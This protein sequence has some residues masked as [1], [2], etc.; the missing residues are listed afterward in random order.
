MTD[1]REIAIT[2]RYSHSS[3]V[4]LWISRL[5]ERKKEKE[6]KK[7]W[8]F[9]D[10]LF[11]KQKK[12]YVFYRD[13]AAYDSR[14]QRRQRRVFLPP[15]S[16]KVPTMNS[17]SKHRLSSFVFGRSRFEHIRTRSVAAAL[18]AAVVAA[19]VAS[20]ITGT[21]SPLPPLPA[22]LPCP[23]VQYQFVRARRLPYVRLLFL[24]ERHVAMANNNQQR[25]DGQFLMRCARQQRD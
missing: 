6:K 23:H 22:C 20:L 11:K 12:G 19:A 9:A 24:E 4:K 5:K 21:V 17:L 8:L 2:K 16:Q 15:W 13:A 14:W 25:R 1:R 18:A 3:F 10:V 7:I